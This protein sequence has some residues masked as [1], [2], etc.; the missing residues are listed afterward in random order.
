MLWLEHLFT[1]EWAGGGCEQQAAFL[2]AGLPRTRRLLLLDQ[3]EGLPRHHRL[4]L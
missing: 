4:E 2:Q 3:L 1:L